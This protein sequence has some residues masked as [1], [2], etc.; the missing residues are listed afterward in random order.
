M[1]S[2]TAC[3]LHPNTALKRLI[4]E[5]REYVSCCHDG[6]ARDRYNAF[7]YRYMLEVP[8][9]SRAIAAKLGVVKETVFNYVNRCLD[10]MLALWNQ[11]AAPHILRLYISEY[12]SR[13]REQAAVSALPVLPRKIIIKIFHPPIT[14]LRAEARCPYGGQQSP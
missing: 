11:S 5:Y 4:G 1:R 8:V 12:G 2:S 3:L 7:V 9:G 13:G 6:Q 10:E 14:C